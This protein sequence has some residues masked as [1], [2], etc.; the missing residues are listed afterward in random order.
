[1]QGKRFIR[2]LRLKN[3]LSYG[4]EGEEIELQ[5][6]NVLIGPNA[7]G[8]SNL[9]DAVGILQSTPN[10]INIPFRQG[11]G[12][13]EWL[14]KGDEK[15]SNNIPTATI[16]AT[17]DYP[18]ETIPLR[19]Q[20]SFTMEGP[21]LQIVGEYVENELEL[22]PNYEDVYFFYRYENGN[23]VLNIRN[24]SAEGKGT[25]TN[26][27]PR[28]LGRGEINPSQSV[29][30]QKQDKDFYPELAYLNNQFS[31]I[32]IYREWNLGRYTPPRKPQPSDLPNDFLEEDASN[33]AHVLNNLEYQGIKP[34]LI[35]QLQKFYEA[36]G[37]IITKIEGSTIQ[38]F[39][40]D[41]N[42][43]RPIPA[44]RLSDGTLRY[45][46]LLTLLCHP[47]PPPLICIEEPELGLHPDILSTVAE[48][49]IA[50]SKRTQIIVTT[51]SDALV[52]GLSEV[53]ESVLVCEQNNTGS[54]L[55]RLEPQQLKKWL[56]KYTLGDLWRMGHIGG[57]RW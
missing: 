43:N 4:S 35:E 38:T 8:K 17:V 10:D 7:S 34:L 5:P 15:N 25:Y 49:L 57:N 11:G 44:T 40:R 9:I 6:L 1:M 16:E 24:V 45:L 13:G 30:S 14:W 20:I 33:L 22:D 51:H 47:S 2:T 29:L 3:F 39:L 54:H 48:L 42:F 50:A 18:E 52:S 19:Y 31:N 26:R 23:P 36:V 55:R 32:R 53:P 37:D 56:E 41:K 46:C 28:H 27:S 21:K 12:I